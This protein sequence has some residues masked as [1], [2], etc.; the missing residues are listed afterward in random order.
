MDMYRGFIQSY[1]YIYRSIEYYMCISFKM[2]LLEYELVYNK[3]WLFCWP[4]R[5]NSLRRS[6]H[7]PLSWM[8]IRRCYIFKRLLTKLHTLQTYK[9]L[10]HSRKSLNR[11]KSPQTLHHPLQKGPTDGYVANEFL[12]YFLFY[13]AVIKK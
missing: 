6:F 2:F 10:N 9:L 8:I 11:S 7:P 1:I 3:L 5:N 12:L 13:I 4:C